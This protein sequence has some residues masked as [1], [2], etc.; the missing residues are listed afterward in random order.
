MRINRLHFAGGLSNARLK[1]WKHSILFHASLVKLCYND[2]SASKKDHKVLIP[3][4]ASQGATY[5]HKK[6][7]WRSSRGGESTCRVD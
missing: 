5:I 1:G 4:S 2:I 7:L 3:A 6:M